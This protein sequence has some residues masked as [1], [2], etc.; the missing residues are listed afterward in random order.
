MRW[1]EKMTHPY[2]DKR[3]SSATTALNALN[4]NHISDGYHLNL[5]PAD[6]KVI[7]NCDGDKLEIATREIDLSLAFLVLIV[8]CLI[9]LWYFPWTWVI[10]F[11]FTFCV[12]ETP[13]FLKKHYYYIVSIEKN[14]TI[15]IG[16][17]KELSQDRHWKQSFPFENIYL[18]TYNPGCVF[19][20]FLDE[21]G[22]QYQRGKVTMLPRLSVHA[23]NKEFQIGNSF[24]SQAEYWW[25]A[26]ELSE[27]LG[28]E[29]KIIYPTPQL[30]PKEN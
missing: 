11:A 15:R 3:F 23:G 27:F 12:V 30:P 24:L 5:K 22:K 9:L 10:I 13:Q 26:Q 29:V 20:R 7:L 6:S 19:D 8:L 14:K 4:S 2:L 17:C 16:T 18:I 28:L 1:L 25:L 21:T